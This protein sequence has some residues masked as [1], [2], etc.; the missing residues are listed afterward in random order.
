MKVGIV[1]SSND[2]EIVWN[3]FRYGNFALATGD[4]LKVFLI[5]KGV[6]L[7]SLDTEVFNIKEQRQAF[8][9]GGG[10]TFA[11]GTCLGIHRLEAPKDSTVATL[12][13]LYEI[14]KESDRILT[15]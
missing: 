4:E 15:F 10:K 5:G 11:C 7:E 14:V 1:L 8:S 2:S 9:V 12:K 6:E 13:D 3:A